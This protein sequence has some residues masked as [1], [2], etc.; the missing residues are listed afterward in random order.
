MMVSTKSNMHVEHAKEVDALGDS[1]VHGCTLINMMHAAHE[2]E[3]AAN[4][5]PM[6]EIAS[7]LLNIQG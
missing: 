5:W 3:K 4:P 7:K 2:E 6:I 1:N